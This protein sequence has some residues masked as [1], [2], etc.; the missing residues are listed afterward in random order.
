MYDEYNSRFLEK[1]SPAG[2]I[3]STAEDMAKYMLFHLSKD[4]VISL[5]HHF[6][7]YLSSL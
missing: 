2:G 4:K 1:M 5:N 7:N 6:K 3:F